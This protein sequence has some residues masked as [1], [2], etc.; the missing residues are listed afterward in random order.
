MKLKLALDEKMMDV[1]LRDRL[2]AEGKLTKEAL[3]KALNAL[4]D[5]AKNATELDAQDQNQNVQ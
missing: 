5:D 2:V 4:S 1:R 3:D